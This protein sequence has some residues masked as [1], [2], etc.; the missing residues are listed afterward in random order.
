MTSQSENLTPSDPRGEPSAA[1]KPRSR[2]SIASY[3][4]RLIGLGRPAGR[5]SP[6]NAE[7]ASPPPPDVILG[8][9][10]HASDEE[11][12]RRGESFGTTHEH[13]DEH[14]NAA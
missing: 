10:A 6:L 12:D 4:L 2:G 8:G 3:L 9:N 11:R 7:P 5:M 14:S 13:P 1:P